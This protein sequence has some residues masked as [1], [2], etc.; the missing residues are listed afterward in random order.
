MSTTSNLRCQTPH[1]IFLLL[2]SS[3]LITYD[4]SHAYV[5]FYFYFLI[6]FL[7]FFIFFCFMFI[8]ILVFRNVQMQL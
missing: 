4:L 7:L 6:I 1:D 2:K 5:L 3:D 8:N